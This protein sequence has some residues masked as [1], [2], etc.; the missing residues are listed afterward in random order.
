MKCQLELKSSAVVRI[1]KVSIA[2]EDRL[3]AFF[4]C[5]NGKGLL[6]Q[7]KMTITAQGHLKT[8]SAAVTEK[9]CYCS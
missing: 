4:S 8:F 1:S 2:A 3:M 6:L 5:S 7:L 9:G